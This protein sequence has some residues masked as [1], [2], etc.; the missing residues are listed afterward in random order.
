MYKQSKLKL[1][2]LKLITKITMLAL[3]TSVRTIKKKKP[4]M[5]LVLEI[6]MMT[7]MTLRPRLNALKLSELR[8]KLLIL[9]RRLASKLKH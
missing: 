7:I 5:M 9:L 3:A 6:L 1:I 4:Q 8:K 2:R